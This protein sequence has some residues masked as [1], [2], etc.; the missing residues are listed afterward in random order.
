[1]SLSTVRAADINTPKDPQK[2]LFESQKA[3]KLYSLH[4]NRKK[5]KKEPDF[6][7]LPAG[8]VLDIAPKSLVEWVGDEGE[9]VRFYTKSKATVTG[10][11]L[12][13]TSTDA[14]VPSERAQAQDLNSVH[15]KFQW[16]FGT[17]ICVL[18]ALLA[19]G[20][21]MPIG[22][23]IILWMIGAILMVLMLVD[24]KKSWE[25]SHYGKRRL[26]IP[27]VHA[28]PVTPTIHTPDRTDAGWAP[29][30]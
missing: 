17:T 26:D 18:P 2:G 10:P 5:K 29:T 6:L 4:P 19:I 13:R 14:E 30:P 12:V 1:M 9:V 24:Q 28:V 3:R 7:V 23:P 15:Q 21:D 22:M 16:I 27:Y 11:A 8:E 20:P 25:Q